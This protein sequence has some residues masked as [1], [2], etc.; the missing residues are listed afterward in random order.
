MDRT[1]KL[2]ACLTLAGGQRCR[3]RSLSNTGLDCGYAQQPSSRPHSEP[4]VPTLAALPKL[5][6][7]ARLMLEQGYKRSSE[8]VEKLVV[9]SGSA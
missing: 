5:R 3:N 1:P 6:P 7:S 4:M 2:K 9:L 8:V